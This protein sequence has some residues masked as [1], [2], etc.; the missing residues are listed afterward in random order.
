[1]KIL[2]I[3]TKST[4]YQGDY[5]EL[6]VLNGL[7]EILGKNCVDYPR[8]DV[9]YH[10]FS[11]INKKN[12]H[13]QGFSILSK[14]F[15]DNVEREN[16]FKNNYDFIIYG[17]GHA[18]DEEVYVE[19]IDK[20]S[21]NTPWI[22]DGHDLYGNA[23]KKTIFNGEE[24]IGNQFPYS[25]KREMVFKEKNVF[26]SGFGIPENVIRPIALEK[27]NQLIQKTYPK[28]A[29][30]EKPTDLG[31][32]KDHHLFDEEDKY[33]DDLQNSWFGLSCKKGGWDSL[34]NYEIIAS[35]TLLLYRDFTKK[36]ILCAPQDLPTI[37]YSSP[38][39]L[40][41]I[42]K[43]L[44]IDNKPSE[45]YLRL[46]RAQREWLYRYGTTTSRA[47]NILRVMQNNSKTLKN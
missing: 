35:G 37:S 32:K 11:S 14:P 41:K 23:S 17:C 33:Y 7:K 25:F 8:K 46:L 28:Y 44:V 36:P 29:N 47:A 1:M 3:T 15:I 18:Y 45:K 31:G 4:K 43:K 21:E 5:F 24:I 16:I 22:L 39:Q 19:E 13:G 42:M 26:P 12:L 34:R 27:K 30:F 40:R 38:R 20:L 2:F 9:I 10:D 6:T